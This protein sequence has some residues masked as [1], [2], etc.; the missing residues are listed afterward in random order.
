M[1]TLLFRH[2]ESAAQSTT[3]GANRAAPRVFAVLNWNPGSGENSAPYA[4]KPTPRPPN[5]R[6]QSIDPAEVIAI[7]PFADL[8]N[9]SL[10]QKGVNGVG[11]L[12]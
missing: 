9:C 8:R 10:T 3:R 5:L 4:C 7:H 1:S 2:A 12:C 6:P 11:Q